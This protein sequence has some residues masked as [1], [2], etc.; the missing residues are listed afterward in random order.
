MTEITA[1]TPR[2]TSDFTKMA[3]DD[4]ATPHELCADCRAADRALALDRAARS[5]RR[6]AP[7]IR[8]ED[9]PQGLPK[10][11]I[12]LLAAAHRLAHTLSLAQD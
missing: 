9:Y 10:R 3:Y 11:D 5:V 8:F 4:P 12:D 1:S 6:P 2:G 7:S